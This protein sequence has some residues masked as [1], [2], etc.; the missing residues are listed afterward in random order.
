MSN[1]IYRAN[2][3]GAK[4]Q[5]DGSFRMVASDESKDG[6]GEVIMVK[7]WDLTRYVGR[8][9]G[10]KPSAKGNPVIL[11]GHNYFLP[12]IG[13]A[14]NVVKDM[15]R[16]KGAALMVDFEL[17]TEEDYGGSWPENSPSPVQIASMLESGFIRT[18]SV[19]FS[20]LTSEN[21]DPDD[22]RYYAPQRYLSQELNEH[23]IVSIPSNAN[24]MTEAM[25]KGFLER[26]HLPGML[27]AAPRFA[28]V[29]GGRDS[30]LELIEAMRSEC[31]GIGFFMPA[32]KP[33]DTQQQ[34][35]GRRPSGDVLE[36]QV[37]TAVM[38]ALRLP[39]VKAIIQEEARMGVE[40]LSPDE[41]KGL[42]ASFGAEPTS[43]SSPA[44]QRT[45][46]ALSGAPLLSFD[47]IND[48]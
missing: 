40:T 41:L 11:Y 5:V 33:E 1:M 29:L 28:D 9:S 42:K 12:P 37:K 17:A 31:K 7:G 47:D 10:G 21:L 18:G 27:E 14:I 22:E 46:D 19:G 20:P 13:R 35:T 6:H 45:Y 26:A 16:K 4:R 3:F 8:K 24:A 44:L 39:E 23:S 25:S 34:R 32:P 43:S 15:N 2:A 38:N 48:D 30:T 36:E